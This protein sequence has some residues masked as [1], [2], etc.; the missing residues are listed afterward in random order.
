MSKLLYE[1][2][3]FVNKMKSDC[4][5]AETKDCIRANSVADAE[6]IISLFNFLNVAIMYRAGGVPCK[7]VS[8][9]LSR[10]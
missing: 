1:K 2:N 3:Y 5:K 9:N 4:D 6:S 7:S 10:S 8:V